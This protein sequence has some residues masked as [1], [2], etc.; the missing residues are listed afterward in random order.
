MESDPS[1][2]KP[3]NFGQII[4]DSLA[5]YLIEIAEYIAIASIVIIPVALCSGALWALG[6]F[7]RTA[8]DGWS[9]LE[10]DLVA[11]LPYA[12]G[13][14]LLSVFAYPLMQGALIHATEQKRLGQS[15]SIR[16]AYLSAL[17][18]AGRLIGTWLVT[19]LLVLLMMASLFF[20]FF[21]LLEGF[22]WLYVLSA[23]L[24]IGLPFAIYFT[25]KW[26]FVLQMVMLEESR[27][28][29]SLP[30]SSA[31]V[32]GNWWRSLGIWVLLSLA[33]AFVLGIPVSFLLSLWEDPNGFAI[34][35]LRGI[36]PALIV[37]PLS[38]VA[39]TL[40]YSDL[41][42]RRQ[43]YISQIMGGGVEVP[44]APKAE[45]APQM[46]VAQGQQP[47]RLKL[48]PTL[49]VIAVA[50]ILVGVITP[51]VVYLRNRTD[52]G[53]IQVSVKRIP[54]GKEVEMG[55]GNLKTIQFTDFA[56][57]VDFNA[58]VE[59]GDGDNAIVA[60]VKYGED[61]WL[62]RSAHVAVYAQQGSKEAAMDEFFFPEDD[63]AN[64]VSTTVEILDEERILVSPAAGEFPSGSQLVLWL[65][66]G[67][68][69]GWCARMFTR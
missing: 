10:R 65:D 29:Q 9:N 16:Q 51:T 7:A 40:L 3:K 56:F 36:F 66:F 45:P 47:R 62:H 49:V 44:A 27:V 30:R 11:V 53:D 55:H 18:H 57:V 37:V 43:Q 32:S 1:A 52:A 17:R 68:G 67:G 58:S 63:P 64:E 69:S 8:A 42:A 39:Q 54:T 6:D 22:G 59:A 50:V 38:T 26:L 25:I 31:L 12:V 48:K 24:A 23:V 41:R 28:I 34:I 46:P 33:P 20:L 14:L 4:G 13:T 2:F 5:A 15:I 35:V 61:T 19:S 21:A 60:D